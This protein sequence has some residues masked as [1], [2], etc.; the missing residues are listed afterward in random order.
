MEEGVWSGYNTRGEANASRIVDEIT[1]QPHNIGYDFP[2]F[3]KVADS[4]G[5][6]CHQ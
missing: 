4:V 6:T 1:L 3:H 5:N 2:L